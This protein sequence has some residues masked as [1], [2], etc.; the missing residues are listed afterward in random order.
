VSAHAETIRQQLAQADAALRDA[1]A[2]VREAQGEV[3]R[4]ETAMKSL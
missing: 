4:A 2:E 1:Q 3:D